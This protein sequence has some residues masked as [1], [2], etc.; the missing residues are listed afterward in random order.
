[1]FSTV[2]TRRPAAECDE[3]DGY[4]F[5]QGRDSNV[6][7]ERYSE[8]RG[9]DLAAECEADDTCVCYSTNGYLKTQV[10]A[11]NDLKVVPRWTA[12]PC[13]GL[14]VKGAQLMHAFGCVTL[15]IERILGNVAG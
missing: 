11:I 1:V 5:Y 10:A 9:A 14:Y 13:N 12:K 4:T 3:F 15:T 6:G 7:T 2:L 8:K